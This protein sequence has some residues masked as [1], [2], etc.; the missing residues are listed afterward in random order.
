MKLSLII[1]IYNAVPF[2]PRLFEN[3]ESQGVFF[4]DREVGEV[5]FVIDG[6]PDKSEFLILEYQK[7]HP[8]W[9]RIL[10]QENQGQHVAR[11]MG[12][13]FARGEYIV[14]MDEDDS[15]SPYSLDYLLKKIHELNVEVLRGNYKKVKDDDFYQ[16]KHFKENESEDIRYYNGYQILEVT[17]N[18]HKTPQIW[19]AIYRKEFLLN[20]NILFPLKNIQNEDMTFNWIMALKAKKI[21]V[22][23]RTVYF[24]TQ[25][26]NSDY[27]RRDREHR[28]HRDA[29]IIEF[30]FF[31]NKIYNYYKNKKDLP[32]Q[33]LMR[34]KQ[35]INWYTFM[36]WGL[37][38]K[39][40]GLRLN[41]I[42]PTIKRFKINEIYPFP[43]IY[44]GDLPDGYPRS[45][46]FKILWT[47][48]SFIPILKILLFFRR[49]KS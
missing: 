43:H 36:Y 21:A 35:D 48:I 46:S 25:R 4:D 28:M 22:T 40:R 13:K 8:T 18:F 3:L 11:N 41:E 49:S 23:N 34:L 19:L 29:N 14:F 30:I 9:V 15:F 12:I 16:W 2:L 26:D 44:P 47:A 6:S 20:N 37:M 42:N 17:E 5:L 1:P 33:V 45:L 32:S 39:I 10:K 24:H 31:I 38:I 7:I 27:S